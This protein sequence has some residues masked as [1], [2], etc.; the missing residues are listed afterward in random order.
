VL[1]HRLLDGWARSALMISVSLIGAIQEVRV[2]VSPRGLFAC[3]VS[4]L[5][6]TG[7]DLD[8]AFPSFRVPSSLVE[9]SGVLLSRVHTVAVVMLVY[10]TIAIRSSQ[11]LKSDIAP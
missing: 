1:T 10:R 9:H 3:L 8:M 6:V 7:P 11:A 5:P 4:C 2:M